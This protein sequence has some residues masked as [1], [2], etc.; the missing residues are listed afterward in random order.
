M[1]EISTSQS[2]VYADH[3]WNTFQL[4]KSLLAQGWTDT[5]GEL[6]SQPTTS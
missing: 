4:D 6:A 3:T 1:S 2:P 5:T